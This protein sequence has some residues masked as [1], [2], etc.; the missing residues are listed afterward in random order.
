[1]NHEILV[2]GARLILK[3]LGLD[4]DSEGIAKTPERVACMFEELASCIDTDPGSVVDVMFKE[5]YDEL[6]MVRDISFVSLC[7]HHLLPFFGRAHVGYLPNVDGHVTGLSKL[8]RVV[9]TVARRPGLQERMTNCVA[10][11]LLQSLNPRGVVVVVEAEHTCMT[12]R[13]ISKPGA[14]TVT[15]AMRGLMRTDTN[16]RAEVLSLINSGR[17]TRLV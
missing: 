17:A 14:M 15:S 8:A 6:V 2:E 11:T 5:S 13:G 10:D 9:D 1:M 12:F 16:T 4:P 3:G 7:E